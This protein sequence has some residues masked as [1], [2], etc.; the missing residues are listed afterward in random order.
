MAIKL[1]TV[2]S[3]PALTRLLDE[4]IG[5]EVCARCDGPIIKKKGWATLAQAVSTGRLTGG[6]ICGH[7]GREFVHWFKAGGAP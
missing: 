4:A 2:R 6:T 7:C 1:K 3:N 5:A